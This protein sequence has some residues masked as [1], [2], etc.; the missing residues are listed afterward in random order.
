[1]RPAQVP[2]NGLVLVPLIFSVNIWFTLDDI[3]G[4]AWIILNSVAAT[5][6]FVLISGAVYIINDLKDIERDRAHPRKRYRAIASGDLSSTPAKAALIVA[7]FIGF[8]IAGFLGPT[9][10]VGA[11]AYFALNI[12]YTYWAK[13]VAILDI[14]SVAAGFVIRALAGALAIDGSSLIIDG[15]ETTIDIVVSP[16]LYIVTALG[17]GMLALAKRRAELVNSGDQAADQRGILAEYTTQFLDVLIVITSSATLIAYTLYTFNFGDTGGN[18]P[19]DKT[20]MLTIPFVVYGVFRYLYLLYV[21]GDGEAPEAILW[22]DR[23]MILN[24]LLW[25]ITSSAILLWHT[26]NGF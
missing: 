5:I 11:G 2:K 25:L 10:I 1:M 17:A 16:W 4:M 9:M 12:G 26:A 23:P 14:I 3:G 7:L 8:F 19:G 6:A 24:L 13:N 21:R 15:I 20:M 18:V 22:N